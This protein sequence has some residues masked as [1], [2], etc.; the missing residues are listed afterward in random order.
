[1]EFSNGFAV[2][3]LRPWF[4]FICSLLFASKEHIY[5]WAAVVRLFASHRMD[6]TSS[7]AVRR[8]ICEDS[9]R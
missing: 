9:G 8:V 3:R 2:L 4:D 6:G 5:A 1:V 7:K